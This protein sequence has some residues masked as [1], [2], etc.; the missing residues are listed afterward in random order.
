[1]SRT[2]QR[3]ATLAALSLAVVNP[4]VALEDDTVVIVATRTPTEAPRLPARVES[5]DRVEIEEKALVT[6]VD[7][8]RETPGLSVVATGQPGAQ[9][10]VFIRGANSKH[11]LAL[12]DG[13]RINDPTAPN[14]QYDFGQDL[15]G[16]V[17]RVEVLRGAG[18]SVHG[19]DA[20]GGVVNLI[21]RRGGEDSVWFDVSGGSFATWRGAG[22]ASGEIGALSYGV[23]AEA[24][25][26]GG[27]DQIPERFTTRTGDD[28][29]SDLATV[30]GSGVYTLGSG[31]SV[32]GLVRWRRSRA[33]F[34]TFSGGPF[35][36]QRADDPDLEIDADAY[37][38]WR[39]GAQREGDVATLRIAGGQVLNERTERDGAAVTGDV[40]GARSFVDL[41]ASFER[42]ALG[43]FADAA[44][45]IGGQWQN[46]D[47]D[48]AATLFT[49]AVAI[50][51]R[52]VSAFAVGRGRLGAGTDLALSVRIDDNERFGA[53]TTA[54]A[55]VSQ[56]F[57]GLRLYG[58]YG[59]SF[60]APTLS[61]RFATN[62]FNVGNAALRAERGRSGEI[63]ADWTGENLK[64]GATVY[65]TRVRNLIDYD[66]AALSNINVDRARLRGLE[67]F[68]EV[69]NDRA[70]LRVNY[71]YT[72]ARDVS[73]A[74]SPRLARRAPHIWSLDGRLDVTD[75]LG[76]NL[77][78]TWIS[79][80]TDV[81]YDNGGFFLSGA[82]RTA[83]YDTGRVALTYALT[84][85][86]D[87]YF[88]AR[89][90]AD[91]GYEDPNAFRGA[92]RNVTLGLRGRF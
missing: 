53:E 15:L 86:L 19:S 45:V 2:A 12:Y 11:T 84:D 91:T 63:G 30:A 37:T 56:T 62:F 76:V 22:G 58:S 68:A 16:D 6:L 42:N 52:T 31:Y 34:D 23:S 33:A 9:T 17:E 59:T 3:A 39:L 27:F 90:V 5:V 80:R 4:A 64:L 55:G 81:L 73:A 13:V 35:F 20:I 77:G 41:T 89:N 60:K 72:D 14:G 46:E 79:S 47:I 36:D 69:R 29:G 65:E 92:P 8:L 26:T 67:S 74:G 78:W 61:E 82:G 51:E 71:T 83:G 48:N 21:P 44:L 7:A 43:L 85:A 1:M 24:L 25:T 87:V 70:S 57:G 40:E 32:D 50:E 54:T 66:F 18:S 28:D 88:S 38:L 75:K 10:S 49:N